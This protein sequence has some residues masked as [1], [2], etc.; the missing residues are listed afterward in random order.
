MPGMNP[1]LNVDDQK[2]IA[3]FR[4]AL[5]HQ[6]LL[7]LL[8]FALL[9]LAVLAARRWVPR[10]PG[11]ERP[12]SVPVG[13]LV[14]MVGFGNLWLF[15]GF[16]QAQSKMALGL[17]S[18]V[19]EP[20]ASS[21]PPWVQHLVNWA[22]TTWS[23]H[24]VQ[25]AAA[26]VWIQVGLGIWLIA[27]TRGGAGARL[28]GLASVGWGLV[29]WVF[30]EAF[31]GIFTS[32]QSWLS[33]T[34]GAVLIYVVAGGLI[35][36]PD[37]AWRSP[38]LGRAMLL[39]LGVL[40]G[41]MAV[42]QA[43]PGRGSWQGLVHGQLGQVAGMAESMT[44]TPQ[45]SFLID[46][47]SSFASFD[48]AHGFAINLFVVLALAT[49][50]LV[51]AVGPFRPGGER[52]V[53]P[54]LIG[55]AV[56]CL[57]V[58]VAIQDLGFLGGLGTD[59][60]TMIPFVLLAASG[61]LAL[62]RAPGPQTAP[63][64]GQ[65]P[66]S[67]VESRPETAPARLLK[68]LSIAGTSTV[69]A[70]GGAVLIVLGAVPMAVAE[71]SPSADP[72]L[73]NSIAGPAVSV[74]YQAPG[75][76]LTGPDGRRVS[77][78]SLRGKVVVLSFSNPACRR[79]CPPVAAEFSA[80]AGLLGPAASGVDFV[81]AGC[82]GRPA[83]V[84]CLTGPA[85]LIAQRYG[86]SPDRTYA[87]VIGKSGHVRWRYDLGAGPGSAATISSFAVLLAAAARQANGPA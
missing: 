3:A 74:N 49:T 72:I 26:A 83:D 66:A 57:I 30:G 76:A 12:A 41:G 4:A 16:L 55:F 23:Y 38:R 9:G 22:G 29:V 59:P 33:G 20:V 31:G 24:P 45:P 48:A 17:P 40:L 32:G 25:A 5:L 27:A 50:G 34:P 46:V 61:Y 44:L 2:V 70:V 62:T 39:G 42:L 65:R 15:D 71:A 85:S 75:F 77:L 63:A 1:G 36:L 28:A 53:R 78:R 56:L 19:I 64:T 8:I 79:S 14:L 58:W 18:E 6:G 43:W 37:R 82:A 68:R 54:F 80:A 51:F 81:V 60:N 86:G 11:A 21:S 87:Y 52:I 7:A 10:E 47:L 35:A 73:A 13:R 84:L 67:A 69:L